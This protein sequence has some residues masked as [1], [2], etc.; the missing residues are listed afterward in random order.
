MKP[1]LTAILVVSLVVAF[2]VVA[3]QKKRSAPPM[4]TDQPS[5]DKPFEWTAGVTLEA[6]VP[7]LVKLPGNIVAKNE[8]VGSV[9]Q[10]SDANAEFAFEPGDGSGSVFKTISVRL[11]PGVRLKLT[12]TTIAWV[13]NE[14]G[15]AGE[16]FYMKR[17][18]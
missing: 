8:V 14:K 17:V 10:V 15:K 16:E 1:S 18:P 9:I 3:Y 4:L 7:T 6:T 2:A 5:P 12:K 13:Y 11:Q